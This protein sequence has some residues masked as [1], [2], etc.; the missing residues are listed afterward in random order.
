VITL[1]K[2]NILNPRFYLPKFLKIRTKTAELINFTI[3]EAQN[4]VLHIIEDLRAKS[5]P[6]RLIILKARQM[7]ISTLSEGLIFNDTTTSKYKNS[8]IIAHED[9]AS[10]NL[11]Q[12][13]KTFYENLPPELTPMT[14]HANAGELSFENP[15]QD[16]EEKRK[17][18]GLM[19]KVKVAT[20][21][22]VNTGRSDMI[23]NLHASEV[24]FW[25]DAKTL[26]TGLMQ[27]IPDQPNTMVIIESTANG[28]GGY[29][30]DMWKQAERGEND[31]IPIFLPW[32]TDSD[33]TRPFD[34]IEDKEEFISKVNAVFK[35]NSGNTVHTEEYELLNNFNLTYEQLNWRKWTIQNKC[36]GDVEQ[37]CQE[38]PSTPDEAFIASG[39]PRFSTTTLKQYRKNCKEGRR[40]YLEWVS[41]NPEDFKVKFIDDPKGYIE[42]WKEPK[43]DRFYCVGADVAEG[44]KE[45]DYSCGVV[46]SDDFDIYACWYGHI[47]PDLFGEELTKLAVY[48]NMAYLGIESN[49]HGL[50]A[51]KSVQRLEYWNIFFQKSY[52]KIS[53]TISQKVGWSTTTRTKPLMINKLAEFIREKWLGIKWTT[54]V[55]E[56]LT[57]IIEDNGATNAQEG[58]HDDTVM[59]TAIMLQLILEGKGEN[60]I[61]FTPDE[62]ATKKKDGF[63]HHQDEDKVDEDNKIEVAE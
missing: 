4:I 14:K 52:D 23:H 48:Y 44:L 3:N 24:A 9:S 20:A 58:C 2:I 34:S 51:I 45:G 25:Q 43:E 11:Y 5:K 16:I 30:Y 60:Y 41:K 63:M 29:F 57:Y 21:R 61:P 33:Y 36:N 38:Y 17:N 18:P 27:T 35:D 56:C 12:M 47:D 54:L 62:K 40:G 31:F 49:N 6:V 53:D 32:F 26:M 7:G 13:Y 8:L 42:I 37:F 1:P 50:T 19:S 28:V 22:N 59:A 10:Q 39:R 15:T 46:G 55:N